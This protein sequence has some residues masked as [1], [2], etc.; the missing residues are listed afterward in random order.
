[1]NKWSRRAFVGTGIVAGGALIVGVGIRPGHRTPNLAPLVQGEGETLIS[2]WV[3]IAADNSITTIIPHSEMGQGIHTSLA[4]MLADELDADWQTVNI[5]EAPAHEDYANYAL[6]KGYI[7]GDIKIPD[8]LVPTID[9]AFLKIAQTMSLQ[10][11]GG[12]SSIRAT[13]VHGMRVAGAAARQILMEAAS[14]TWQ[15]PVSEL[16]TENSHILHKT[17]NRSAPY[18]DFAQTA[19]Q[20]TPP[21]APV[22]KNVKDYKI[23]GTSVQRLDIPEK[24]DGSAVFGIDAILPDM[25]HA[26]VS[27]SPVFGAQI[28]SVDDSAARA[29]PGVK[30]V[31]RLENATSGL[32]S[33][34]AVIADGFWQAKQALAAVQVTYSD[35]DSAD[36][37]QDSLYSQF[38][39]ELDKAKIDGTTETDVK[40]GDVDQTFA[41]ANKVFEAEYRV[42]YLAHACMEPLNCTAWMHDGICEVW[43]GCQNPLGFRDE[44]AHA[45]ELDS[46]SVVLHNAYLGGGFGR[47]AQSDYA[48]QA[49]LLAQ[50]VDVPV[51]LIWTREEDIRQDN[52]RQASI[53][54]FRAAL[55]AQGEI[56]AWENQFV[57]KHEPAEAP[58]TPY[59]TNSQYIHYSPSPSH[60]RWGPW[61]SVDHSL[62]GFFT[63][64]FMDEIAH[65]AGK[66]SFEFRRNALE[67]ESR[68]RKVLELAARRANWTSPLPESWGRGISLQESFGSIV[69]Q[70][71]EIEIVEGKVRVDRVVCV[72]DAGFAIS[73]D[74]LIAQMESGIIYGLTAALYGEISIEKGAV[75]QSNFHDYE[76]LRMD[77][78]PKIE[79]YI[80]NSG[81]AVGGA[82]EPGTPGIAPALTNAIFNATGTRIRSLPV[83]NFDLNFRV[84]E[85]ESVVS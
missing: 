83:K 10:I 64:S 61:R 7:L 13:G 48:V 59:K 77:E 11:T 40:T 1:M 33:G 63:E 16:D 38:V 51:K 41:Q 84:E 60:V 81:A 20:L 71:V 15:V 37:N 75:V 34:V 74:G 39:A 8:A 56:L 55:G 58:Y 35:T 32:N 6:G 76:M 62:H 30:K 2:A 46:S 50:E 36:A 54:R 26:T 4:M 57:E 28:E 69:A 43:T 67:P 66:D 19:A 29:M 49:A 53:S 18:S 80:V 24:V 47:R 42:P 72:V 9:G 5:M 27:A 31:V 68:H 23:M 25:L 44:I 21:S 22:L 82:G 3:K 65:T 14:D 79:T 45:L 17:S 52:Y 73:P 85:T 70:V 12:S 78:A